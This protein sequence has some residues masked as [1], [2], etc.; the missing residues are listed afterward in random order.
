MNVSTKYILGLAISL[1]LFSCI[2]ENEDTTKPFN[3]VL[4]FKTET[5]HLSGT[6]IKTVTL[7]D[8]IE[9]KSIAKPNWSI[10]LKP[11]LDADFN[12]AANKYNYTRTE[13][14]SKLT[15]LKDV[16]WISKENQHVKK[17]IYRYSEDKCVAAFLE[18]NKESAVYS[19]SEILSYLPNSGYSI[20]NSQNLSQL[21]EESFHLSGEFA[22]KP[23]P[24]KMFFDIGHNQVVPV[25]F[26][27]TSDLENPILEFKQGKETIKMVAKKTDSNYFVD[28]P[29]FNAYLTFSVDNENMSGEFH[30]LDKGDNY[31]IPFNA[32]R[33]PYNLVT[34]M[35]ETEN[36]TNFDGKW[37]V[38][39]KEGDD[40]SLAIGLFDRMGDDLYGTFATETGDY[41]FL[42]GKVDGDSFSLST[43]D[44]SHLFIFTGK[45]S[46]DKIIDGHFYSGSHYHTTW[47]GFK[48]ENVQLTNPDKM[49]TL[50]EGIEQIN[51]TFP[52]LNNEPIS[53]SDNQFKN[54]V[55]IIQ[56]LGSWCPNCMDET[57]YFKELYAKYNSDG[58]EIIGLAF[59]RSSNFD[60]AKAS[61]SKAI[62]D[63][64][65]PYTILV[66]GTPKESATALPMITPI[67]SYPTSIV[68]DKNGKVVKIH[69]GFYGPSTGS[70]YENY[71]KEMEEL[72]THLLSK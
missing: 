55:V 23:Q 33:L 59:E 22:G 20:E 71:T 34:P 13:R 63:L 49:T 3:D 1:S 32:S 28:V 70:Y 51:F 24:W 50:K 66:A 25:N 65:V 12:T 39:F 31:V 21:N 37:E 38:H 62:S 6:L 15:N 61:L 43:F 60:E 57:R 44:G 19:H 52:N 9:T 64:E 53:L 2:Q 42:Q 8:K 35:T 14:I 41:R 26:D 30:N 18:L 40:H 58:L 56:I 36:A 69:T 29:V 46:N 72:I 48:N 7:N 5:A 11:F 67:K 16:I 17:A 10:E 47:N 27:F 54:K 45:I 68:I 4:D